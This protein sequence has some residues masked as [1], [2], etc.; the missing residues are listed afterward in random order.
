MNELKHVSGL[1]VDV[2]VLIMG[3][4]QN[5]VYIISDGSGTFVVDPSCDAET[6]LAALG[7][8]KLDGIV[9]THSHWDHTGAAAELKELT[10][11]PVY[12]SATDAP[13][14]EDPHESGTSRV[15]RACSVDVRLSNGD[16]V[17]IGDMKWKVMET[18]GHTKGSICLFLI[19]QFGN[20]EGG[21]PVLISGDTLFKGTFGRT[22]FEGGSMQDMGASMKKLAALPDDVVV[23]PGHNDLTLI[24]NERATFAVF[25][26]EP[27]HQ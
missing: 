8:R 17:Q 14:I 26:D 22:D 4:L 18:P 24:G 15:A 27:D 9:L 13:D 3:P 12:A 10:G 16:I 21:L 20:H 25:G 1:C 5:N 19:P 2:E 7:K 6:I 23:L 11:A